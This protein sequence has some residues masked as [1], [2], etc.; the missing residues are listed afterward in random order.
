MPANGDFGTL[1]GRRGAMMRNQFDRIEGLEGNIPFDCI[2]SAGVKG[3]LGNPERTDR[4]FFLHTGYEEI[5]KG[6]SGWRN[7]R[8]PL[9]PSF[10][11]YNDLQDSD[12]KVIHG[13]L[14]FPERTDG[15]NVQL[16]AQQLGKGTGS[17]PGGG[18]WETPPRGMPACTGDGVHAR[19][20]NGMKDDAPSFIDISCPNRMCHFRLQAKKICGALGR[21]YF[22]TRWSNGTELP[23]ILVRYQTHGWDTASNIKGMFDAV[24]KIA[25]GLGMP[26]E[27]WCFT[28][29]PFEMSIGRKSIPDKKVTDWKGKETTGVRFPVVSFALGNV[30]EF[31]EWQASAR[32]KLIAGVTRPVA[33]LGDGLDHEEGSPEA[34]GETLGMLTPGI[35][36]T[37]GTDGI[38]PEPP[39]AEASVQIKL[40]QLNAL[41][42]IA[43]TCGVTLKG[44]FARMEWSLP[45][46]WGDLL[47]SEYENI[48]TAIRET[49]IADGGCKNC[50]EVS[51]QSFCSKECESEAKNP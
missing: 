45:K 17:P 6:K 50:G 28:G 23:S 27:A 5:A 40:E 22:R 10:E 13:N 33:L 30:M 35:P 3:P 43:K 11:S 9:H 41:R 20:Y 44:T 48:Q 31:L 36:G 51:E 18:V 42:A 26:R 1:G 16:A 32:H 4:F 2:V 25:D 19:R 47:A 38:V 49:G 34:I 46:S 21:L 8:H 12:A 7:Q 29:L 39:A 24:E 37:D 14:V 15:M